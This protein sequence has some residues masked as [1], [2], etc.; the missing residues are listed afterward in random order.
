MPILLAL[1]VLFIAALYV[2]TTY[3]TFKTLET[4]MDASVQ[5]IGNQLKRQASLIP[6]LE[7]SV[8]GYM[9]QEK[10]IFKDLTDA[11]KLAQS[12]TSSDAKSL[13]SLESKLKSILPKLQVLV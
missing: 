4:R 12:S 9:K 3:N 8:K 2:M 6:N 11:R 10:S 5:E 1:G 13:D 7:T